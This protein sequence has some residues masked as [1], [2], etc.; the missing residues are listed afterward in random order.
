[1]DSNDL[2]EGVTPE[3]ALEVASPWELE[4]GVGQAVEADDAPDIDS[5][6]CSFKKHPG[7]RWR[8]RAA[9]SSYQ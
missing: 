1:M 6:S 5:Y 7:R 9:C 4:E 8:T 2:L 3:A